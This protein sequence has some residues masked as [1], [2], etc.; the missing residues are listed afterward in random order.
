[1]PA[2]EQVGPAQP[3]LPIG[4]YAF[5][6]DCHSTALVSRLGSVDWACFRR[7]DSATA[8]ARLLDH[9][10]G[11]HFSITARG[12]IG[13]DRAY[14]DGTL[15]LCTTI[16][17]ATGRARLTEAMVM[18]PGGA[19]EPHHELVRIIDGLDGTVTFDVELA[20]R[21]DY[22]CT[23]PLVRQVHD[24]E[25]TA[26][27]GPAAL[28]I[29][30]DASLDVSRSPGDFTGTVEVVEGSACRFL[31]T[32]RAAH[33]VSPRTKHR[34]TGYLE[35]ADERLR[36]TIDWWQRWNRVSGETGSYEAM[37]ATSVRVLK[38][39]TCA[40][41]GAVIAAATTSLPEEPGSNRNWDY[42][43]SWV[44]DSSLV[45]DALVGTG[46]AEIAA[47]F[48]NFLVRSAAG[49][50]D[51]LRI[52]YGAYGE[53][54]L[55]ELELDLAG[56]RDSRPVRIG[57]GAATQVQLDVYGHLL[58]AVDTWHD[59]TSEFDPPE[60]HFL[61]NAV[62]IA[63]RRWREP[64]QGI[65]EMRGDPRHFVNSKVMC[66]V[67]L[68]RGIGLAPMLHAGAD[69]VAAWRAAADELRH[70]VMTRGVDPR[71]GCFRQHYDTDDVDA[72][73]LK[74]PLVGFIAPDHPVMLATVA[75]IQHDLTVG[76][77]GFIRRYGAH[78]D[79]GVAQ[80][81]NVNDEG[82]FLLATCWLVEVLCLQGRR[83]DAVA[84]F[85]R[86]LS[87]ANDL[88]LYSEEF[89]V[90]SGELLGNFPQAFTHLGVLVAA[91]RLDASP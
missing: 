37:A 40:P 61:R 42:R 1:V 14:L 67:A 86:I 29:Q 7:F 91:R 13:Y 48:H 69:D 15:V 27:G 58:D 80:D 36:T 17:T 44:R 52:M 64:D 81:D 32:S 65:W 18:R 84:L 45:L 10:R 47:G 34:D 20:P 79:D 62:D 73:L 28:I 74:L 26:V 59:G 90:R 5:L 57:N 88:G 82:V 43:Y 85:E 11:G 72:S 41:T 55:P 31:L 21:F 54:R 71:R 46:H 30:T 39:L 6:S 4:E 24:H 89:D 2:G 87:C 8:F 68:D 38:G 22:G 83:A 56:W 78:V 19:D 33:Q 3:Y 12:A 60:C 16:T 76:E 23:I 75:A 51:D 63:A 70:E 9:D 53:R 66:W 25:Y 49:N 50:A 35:D 77:S